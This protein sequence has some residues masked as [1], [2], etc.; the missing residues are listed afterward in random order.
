MKIGFI[1]STKDRVDF[2]RQVLKNLDSESGFDIIWMDGSETAEG[3]KLLSQVQFK[4]CSLK[5]IYRNQG[6]GPNVI[7]PKG[8]SLL[9]QEKYDYCGLIENDVEM[10]PGWFSCL[11]ELFE[12]GQ[13]DNIDVGAATIRTIKSRI[14][15]Y[16]KHYATI[17]NLGAGMVLF[18]A[19]AAGI[20]CNMYYGKYLVNSEI[21]SKYYKKHFDNSL[22]DVYELWMEKKNRSLGLDWAYAMELHKYHLWCLGSVPSMATDFGYDM[23]EISR[24]SYA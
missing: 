20:I 11:M 13:K 14:L 7:I 19:R 1:F 9:L 12:L 24:T 6:G 23:K 2:T 17:W 15:E 16:K 5:K 4:N 8:L 22:A 18:S 3:K 10:K 21:L